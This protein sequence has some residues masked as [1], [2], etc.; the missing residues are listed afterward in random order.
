MANQDARISQVYALIIAD[1]PPFDLEIAASAVE[2]LYV[3]GDPTPELRLAQS[4]V[5]FLAVMDSAAAADN[6]IDPI[7]SSW[8]PGPRWQMHARPAGGGS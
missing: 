5:E 7:A 6:P 2:F 8:V 1:T 3:V 4:V